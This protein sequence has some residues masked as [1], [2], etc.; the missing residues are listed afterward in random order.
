[1]N[2]ILYFHVRYKGVCITS[3]FY[4]IYITSVFNKDD[5][6]W[7]DPAAAAAVVAVFSF[8]LA[9][10]PVPLPTAARSVSVSV[11]VSHVDSVSLLSKYR[12]S[13]AADLLPPQPIEPVIMIL[14]HTSTDL[15]LRAFSRAD[16]HISGDARG[17]VARHLERAH[18]RVWFQHLL[19]DKTESY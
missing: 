4:M 9:P 5:R 18:G 14:T 10:S 1:M 19:A 6:V 7:P 15:Q 11:L 16:Q 12:G 8:A 3:H 13:I 2:D 17:D